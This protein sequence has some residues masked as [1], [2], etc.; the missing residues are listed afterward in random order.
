MVSLALKNNTL[1][2][3][4]DIWHTEIY[5]LVLIKSHLIQGVSNISKYL[6]PFFNKESCKNWYVKQSGQRHLKL[7]FSYFY[8]MSFSDRGLS[9]E[10]KS[11][12]N[13]LFISLSFWDIDVFVMQNRHIP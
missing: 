8:F 12:L 11:F 10:H 9:T 2:L 7:I 3:T 13:F 1:F 6:E 5:Y 4:K